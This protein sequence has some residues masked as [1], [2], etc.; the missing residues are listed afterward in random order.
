MNEPN[1]MYEPRKG[2]ETYMEKICLNTSPSSILSATIGAMF[3]LDGVDLLLEGDS[4]IYLTAVEK[5]D[6]FSETFIHVRNMFGTALM[7]RQEMCDIL[8]SGNYFIE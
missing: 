5:E 3:E 8:V 1:S 6:V 4:L 7:T 2:Y